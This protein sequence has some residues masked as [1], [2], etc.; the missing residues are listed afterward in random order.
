MSS[1]ST[2]EIVHDGIANA[3]A[4]TLKLAKASQLLEWSLDKE[5]DANN[6]LTKLAGTSDPAAARC[7]KG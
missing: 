7:C 4:K 3:R 5:K 6:Q 1:P 2:N